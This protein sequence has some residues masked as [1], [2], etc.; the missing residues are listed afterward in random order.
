M[1]QRPLAQQADKLVDRPAARLECR[2]LGNYDLIFEHILGHRYFMSLERGHEVP[3]T[4]AVADWYDSVYRPL[5]EVAREHGLQARLPGWTDG[6]VYLALTWLWLD[7]GEEGITRIDGN[8]A[9][10]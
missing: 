2:E 10:Y 3:L 5:T 9:L 6:D 1:R 7:L 8:A 4:E